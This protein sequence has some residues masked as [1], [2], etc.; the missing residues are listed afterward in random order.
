MKSQT[1]WHYFQC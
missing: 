1:F